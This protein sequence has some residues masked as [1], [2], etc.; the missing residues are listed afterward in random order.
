V[1]TATRHAQDA[2]S[3]AVATGAG[4]Y[5]LLAERMKQPG[6]WTCELSRASRRR[7]QPRPLCES[8][9]TPC[10]G[11]TGDPPHRPAGADSRTALPRSPANGTGRLTAAPELKGSRLGGTCPVQRVT[12]ALLTVRK[13]Y[14]RN[15]TR[16]PTRRAKALCCE[17]AADLGKGTS[18]DREI[19]PVRA[20]RT[21]RPIPVRARPRRGTCPRNPGP[22]RAAAE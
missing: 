20:H 2:A 19:Y 11:N 3:A 13:A 22:L 4:A 6:R 8:E 21:A 17:M 1:A 5:P 10:S 7:A 15:E 16:I 9:P 12:I 18:K 14:L